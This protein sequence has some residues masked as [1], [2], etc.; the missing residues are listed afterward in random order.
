MSTWQMKCIVGTLESYMTN[1]IF[2]FFKI[3][4]NIRNRL[5]HMH[6][7]QNSYLLCSMSSYQQTRN[8][9]IQIRSITTKTN[10]ATHMTNP[11]QLQPRSVLHAITALVGLDLIVV[12]RCS[13]RQICTDER[14]QKIEE[15]KRKKWGIF[16]VWVEDWRLEKIRSLLICVIWFWGIDQQISFGRVTP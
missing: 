9:F 5:F 7:N 4:I 12:V 1:K 15:K 2:F 11:V 14:N 6:Q 10:P 3:W 13:L 16:V 8:F